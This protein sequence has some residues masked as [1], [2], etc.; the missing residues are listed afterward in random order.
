MWVTMWESEGPCPGPVPLPLQFLQ[1]PTSPPPPSVSVDLWRSGQMVSEIGLG[2]A[3]SSAPSH[4]C[5]L[6]GSERFGQV[7]GQT[8]EESRGLGLSLPSQA[9][10]SRCS[11][12]LC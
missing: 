10:A 12:R 2:A 5:W 11:W 6:P 3:V 8:V 1:T 4:P 7:R 9:W